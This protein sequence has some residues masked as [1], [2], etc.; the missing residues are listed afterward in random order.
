MIYYPLFF[1]FLNLLNLQNSVLV[2]K[3]ALP[4]KSVR[5]DCSLTKVVH[6]KNIF[7]HKSELKQFVH[8]SGL[9]QI[10]VH[11]SGF[12]YFLNESVDIINFPSFTDVN[13]VIDEKFDF[14]FF[15]RLS[16]INMKLEKVVQGNFNQSN[17]MFEENAGKQ[18]AA[19]TLFSI[20]WTKVRR[21]SLWKSFDLDYILHKGDAIFKS[22]NVNGTLHVEDLPEKISFENSHFHIR[23]VKQVDGE[24]PLDGNIVSIDSF[25]DIELLASDN[26]DGVIVFANELCVAIFKNKC[27]FFIF[28]SHSHDACGKIVENCIGKSIL[29]ELSDV[30]DVSE[31]IFATYDFSSYELAYIEVKA[32]ESTAP[33]EKSLEKFKKT[34]LYREHLDNS[35]RKKV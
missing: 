19:M 33:L 31:Y 17:E 6:F 26:I 5:E 18:S 24:K 1:L 34:K 7:V 32:P 13:H 22:I 25:I 15:L 16:L 10:S 12:I 20:C 9:K 14:E 8:K 23:V 28:D 2:C 4:T 27:S 35:K 29:I 21:I 3:K 11:K 30:K